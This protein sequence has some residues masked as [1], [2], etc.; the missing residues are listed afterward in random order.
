[1]EEM[2]PFEL[3]S[4]FV[5]QYDDTIGIIVMVLVP[6]IVVVLILVK[7]LKRRRSSVATP[8]EAADGTPPEASPVEPS[9]P[10]PLLIHCPACGA[11]VSRYAPTCIKCGHPI[12]AAVQTQE[13]L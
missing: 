12:H 5:Q 13:L 8:S 9:E 7:L 6:T 3:L 1:M 2:N 11:E 4:G 10:E